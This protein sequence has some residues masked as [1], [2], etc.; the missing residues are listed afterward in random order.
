MLPGK[1]MTKP[2]L[3]SSGTKMEKVHVEFSGLVSAPNTEEEKL[4][5]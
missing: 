1:E 5:K 3:A 4:L 2:W